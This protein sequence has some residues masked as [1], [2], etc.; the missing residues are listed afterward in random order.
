M[1]LELDDLGSRSESDGFRNIG[2][3]LFTLALLSELTHA[4]TM[5]CSQYED[6]SSWRQ[7]PVNAMPCTQSEDLSKRRQALVAANAHDAILHVR[8]DPTWDICMRAESKQM[9]TRR[10]APYRRVE[11][12]A[13]KLGERIHVAAPRYRMMSTWTSWQQSPSRTCAP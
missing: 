8:E 4:D 6:L 13:Q 2:G 3:E 1:R 7:T 12:Q 11:S 9:P 10:L 5:P